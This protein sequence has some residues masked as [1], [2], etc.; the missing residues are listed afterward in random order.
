MVDTALP[1]DR[2]AARST[3]VVQ[4]LSDPAEIRALLA[5][6]RAYA[7]YAL[8]QLE[9]GMFELSEWYQ[10]T[11]PQGR[12]P[13]TGSGQ[14]LIVHSRSG[15]GRALFAVGDPQALDAILGLHPG[16]RFTFGS[17]R[18]EH[19]PVVQRY[20][21][22][23]REQTMLRMAVTPETFSPA[24]GEA[25]RLSGR[26]VGKINRLYSSEG[27]PTAYTA[28]HI[29]EGVYYGVFEAD[30]LASIAGTHAFS[31]SEGVAVV[32]NVFTHPRCR[33]RGL[34][35]V[36]TTAVT[37][38]LLERCSL[39]V[40]TVEADNTFAV[41]AYQKLGYQ[42]Q[43]ALHETPLIR[44]EPLGLLSLARRLVAGWRG[45]DQGTEV[46]LR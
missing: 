34:A 5:P 15:L 20:F 41:R 2:Q 8:A 11:D 24:E 40:L 43:C 29:D 19:R 9:P 14:A 21:F 36:A 16:P 27:G 4:R 37:R 25:L 38:E 45:R 18:P 28:R 1:R 22:L 30:K 7:A 26:D 3:Y 39:V 46:V 12:A 44:K 17:L 23:T 10:A 6:D 33:N 35:T 13:S 42:S 32:G 31:P